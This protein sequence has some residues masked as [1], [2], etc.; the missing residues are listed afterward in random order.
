MWAVILKI[1][2]ILKGYYII[3]TNGGFMRIEL[4]R[5]LTDEEKDVL[6]KKVLDVEF[7]DYYFN[8]HYEDPVDVYCKNIYGND[9]LDILFGF[10]STQVKIDKNR[11]YHLKGKKSVVNKY[12][13]KNKENLFRIQILGAIFGCGQA[14]VDIG[15]E[16]RVNGKIEES[17]KWYKK[18]LVLC[19]SEKAVQGLIRLTIEKNNHY[20]GVI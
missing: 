13:L 16:Y 11:D 14:A 15:T 4:N 19:E 6:F 3:R 12:A 7:S 5:D 1:L 2:L 18:A 8:F 10:V 17:C 9:T 20:F